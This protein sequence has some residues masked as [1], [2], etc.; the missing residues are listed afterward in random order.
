M[1]PQ[2]TK[3]R[4]PNRART[5]ERCV[6]LR[7]PTVQLRR[8]SCAS[9]REVAYNC[10]TVVDT[11]LNRSNHMAAYSCS[12]SG[13]LDVE[14]FS[15]PD[16]KLDYFQGSAD[17]YAGFDRF[18]RVKQE[19]WRCYTGAGA[20]RDKYTY[21]HDRNSNR[22]YRENVVVGAPSKKLDELYAYDHLNRLT[23]FH[24]GDLDGNKDELPVAGR[25]R[26]QAKRVT[27]PHHNSKVI[28]A[29]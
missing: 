10:G 4:L 25:V 2:N 14:D 15:H 5:R 24:R 20:D 22:L 16:V 3:Q 26:G 13:R 17:T 11:V 9:G 8:I 23:T 19:L 21:G 6:R 12:R 7:R 1:G 28:K 29:A 18:G 27:L